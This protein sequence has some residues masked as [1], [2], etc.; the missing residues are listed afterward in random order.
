MN[1]EFYVGLIRSYRGRG[2]VDVFRLRISVDPGGA[3]WLHLDTSA[4]DR[5]LG[6][7]RAE[8]RVPYREGD[9]VAKC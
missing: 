2:Q 5:V 1:L 7:Q 6:D 8:T 3:L 4:A 9:G